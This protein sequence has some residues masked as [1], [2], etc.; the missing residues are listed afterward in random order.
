MPLDLDQPDSRVVANDG[1]QIRFPA[2]RKGSGRF[3]G[4][5][6]DGR[7]GAGLHRALPR[8][9][10]PVGRFQERVAVAADQEQGIVGP[11]LAPQ[12][13]NEA[14]QVVPQTARRVMI[15]QAPEEGQ[16]KAG[17]QERRDG[18]W[19]Q[20]TAGGQH[21]H[22]S[23]Y[24]GRKGKV[25]SRLQAG[26][27]EE[28]PR[29]RGRPDSRGRQQ[30]QDDQDSRLAEGCFAPVPP[31]QGNGDQGGC[32]EEK[33]GPGRLGQGRRSPGGHQRCAQ[34]QHFPGR[35]R[36][37]ERGPTLHMAGGVTPPGKEGQTRQQLRDNPG[38]EAPRGQ[39]SP[40]PGQ[41]HG[42]VQRHQG[43]RAQ[44]QAMEDGDGRQQ[45]PRE[46]AV[47]PWR[48]RSGRET[49]R[50]SGIL[51][52]ALGGIGDQGHP[53]P[54]QG[55]HPQLARPPHGKGRDRQQQRGEPSRPPAT[56]AA[57]Q[58]IGQGHGD[59]AP[60]GREHPQGELRLAD[61]AAPEPEGPEEKRR[62]DV[63]SGPGRQG[64][65]GLSHG[66]E[67][68]GLVPPQVLVAQPPQPEAEGQGQDADHRQ[69]VSGPF[70][71]STG[72][73]FSRRQH[74]PG[75]PPP[76]SPRAAARGGEGGGRG[77]RPGPGR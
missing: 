5:G 29:L 26:A 43:R 39:A 74:P 27:V 63:A 7:Q 32:P 57:A 8:R 19:C 56:G 73:E 64:G 44:V 10:A 48:G 51:Q 60:E 58:D 45:D 12:D 6:S 15:G 36:L 54:R 17:G 34:T 68:K 69:P 66:P 18:P 13:Q 28:R 77:A 61:A 35:G 9:P 20:P 1:R 70:Q 4:E 62:M 46:P 53:E 33:G 72:R 25:V 30:G 75:Y 38:H 11:G 47:G 37:G 41:A 23:V 65:E 50:G 59:H 67:R 31:G 24:R 16:E 52:P 2:S 22:Q 40:Q 3:A 21:G 71:P 76:G 42:Q 14:L 55:V 49:T